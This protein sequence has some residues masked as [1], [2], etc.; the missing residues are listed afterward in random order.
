M[1]ASVHPDKQ[2]GKEKWAVC[3]EFINQGKLQVNYLATLSHFYSN[4]IKM[5]SKR[6]LMCMW[7]IRN[8]ILVQAWSLEIQVTGPLIESHCVAVFTLLQNEG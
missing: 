7:K 3:P 2:Q 8:I 1:T 6:N 4:N 5:N